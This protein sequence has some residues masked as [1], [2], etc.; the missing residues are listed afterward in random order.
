MVQ[1]KLGAITGMSVFAFNLP[2]L[3]GCTGG[4]PVQMVI[5]SPA[6][7]K[8]VFKHMEDDQGQGARKSGL[9]I[10]VDS[11]LDFNSPMVQ[12]QDR[13]LQG[14]RPRHHHEA[15]GDTLALLV[16]DNYVNRFNLNGR[17]YE[18]IPQVP[19]A[20]RLTPEQLSHYYVRTRSGG[21]WCRSRPWSRSIPA[22]IPMR[23]PS[24][25]SS[26]PPPSPPCR[27]RASPWAR[28][29]ISSRTRPQEMLPKRLQPRL[30]L[31]VRASTS[32]R[33]ISSP[34]PSSSPSSSSTSCWRRS[35]RACAIRW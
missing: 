8:Q 9:F 3:P 17:S 1:G 14:Q 16:G 10:V 30:P 20:E 19:R 33:A 2:P 34:S 22:S 29:S 27:C 13:P 7:F 6:E 28:R 32:A 4:L 24:T 18:V 12:R 25:T 15:I 35:S 21:N 5:N 31:G 11:D 26:I 23:S